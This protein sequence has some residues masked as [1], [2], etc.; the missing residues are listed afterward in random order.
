MSKK[1]QKKFNAQ[2]RCDWGNVNPVTRKEKSI[3]DYRRHPKHK[4]SEIDD[5]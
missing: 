5:Y 1:E 4:G 2:K 3:K